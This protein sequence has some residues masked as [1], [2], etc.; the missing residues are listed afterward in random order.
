MPHL[1]KNQGLQGSKL[2]V[3]G[4][5]LGRWTEDESL[6]EALNRLK[7]EQIDGLDEVRVNIRL[8]ADQHQRARALLNPITGEQEDYNF[9]SDLQHLLSTQIHVRGLSVRMEQGVL[10]FTYIARQR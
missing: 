3:R 4:F 9:C 7:K 6:A 8:N 10:C 1:R 2:P 5:Y